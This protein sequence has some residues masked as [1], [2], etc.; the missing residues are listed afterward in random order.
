M[1]RPF[2][3]S[4]GSSILSAV[5]SL[6]ADWIDELDEATQERIVAVLDLYLTQIESGTLPSIDAIVAEHPD[7]EG[8]LR[9]SLESLRWLHEVPK[10]PN[11][12]LHGSTVTDL[13][14]TNPRVLDGYV[15]GRE[16]GRG[17]MG[18]VYAA[19][20]ESADH[21]VAIKVLDAS[22]LNDRGRIARFRREA[23]AAESLNHPSIVPVYQIGCAKGRHYYTMKLIAGESLALHIDRVFN[24]RPIPESVDGSTVPNEEPIPSQNRY[25]RLA[26]EMANVADALHAAHTTGIVH[27]DIKPSNVLMDTSGHLWITDFGLAHVD[28]GRSLTCSGDII[29]TFQY[30]SPEQASGKQETIDR[31]SDIYSLGATLYELFTG[32]PPYS[33]LDPAEILQRIQSTEPVRPSTY[34][35]DLPR[36]LETIIQ[37]SMRPDKSDRYQSA[38]LLAEDLMRFSAGEPILAAPVSLRERTKNW[39]HIRSTWIAT[40]LVISMIG[41]IA[42]GIHSIRMES[43]Q[44]TQREATRHADEN[45]RQA[46]RAVDTLGLQMAEQLGT[47]AGAEEVRR[48]MFEET[49]GYYEGFIASAN[50]DPRLATDVAQTR[51][52]IARLVRT[53]GSVDE[54]EH[55]YRDAV[56]SLRTLC[57]GKV[58]DPILLTL[59]RAL[60]EWSMI[61]SDQGDQESSKQIASEADTV[62]GRLSHQANRERSMALSHHTRAMVAFREHDLERALAEGN[63]AVGLL[64]KTISSRADVDENTEYTEEYLADALVNLSVILGESGRDQAAALAA[65]QGLA[66]RQYAMQTGPSPDKLKRLA[67]AHNNI[68]SL[69][70]RSG[71]PKEA[72]ESYR[73]AID[74][75]DQVGERVAAHLQPKRE[76]SV[77]LNNLGMAYS[78]IDAYHDAE[79]AFRRGIGLSGIA[80][81]ADPNDAGASQRAA[82]IWNNLGVLLKKQGDRAGAAEAFR[83]ASEYQQRVCRLLPEHSN[84]SSVLSQ[85][86]ANLSSL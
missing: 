83:K 33:G 22:G 46:R 60:I 3:R 17:A 30:M 64:Q 72:I 21:E 13:T 31:R 39:I 62:A 20:L 54:I 67:L 53:I 73:T 43:M 34:D 11:E 66:L 63:L 81:D 59:H 28:D 41:L 26:G 85:I 36:D 57:N 38:A 27:R 35:D 55:A 75:F 84:E 7:L 68:A 49:L 70:W 29:G 69:Q 37:R 6:D 79:Q 15:I 32:H 80:A 14:W 18:V 9:K 5:D 42:L 50:R 47:I 40:A 16:L 78:S 76:L 19:R 71:K 51:L 4:S 25:Q 48:K 65:T 58:E 45:Y 61:R 44:A 10:P 23:R 86:Q 82:G 8:P 52:K 24:R 77:S 74:L 1:I 2:H 56:N 12:Q